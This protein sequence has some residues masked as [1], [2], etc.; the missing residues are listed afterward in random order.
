MPVIKVKDLRVEFVRQLSKCILTAVVMHYHICQ[1]R[2]RQL[3][4]CIPTIVKRLLHLNEKP[5]ISL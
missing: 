1:K 4:K 5:C 2:I 3:S